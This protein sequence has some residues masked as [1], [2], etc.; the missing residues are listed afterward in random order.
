MLKCPVVL[1]CCFALA[2]LFQSSAQSSAQS[3]DP[4]WID[5]LPKKSRASILWYADHEKGD[6]S[7]WE[8]VNCKYPGGG[9]F[10]TGG[11][12]AIAQA[13]DLIAHSGRYSAQATIRGAVRA[14][15]GNRAVRLMR[16]TDRPW[17]HGGQYLPKSAYYSV[18]FF[19]PKA[20]NANKYPPWDPGDG[21]WWN[22]FQFKADDEAG[23]SQ[24]IW[25][26]NVYHDDATGT[27]DLGLYSHVNVPASIEQIKPKPIPIGRWFHLEAFYRV[28]YEKQGEITIWQDGQRILHAGNV[29]TAICLE[30]EHAVWGIGN[31]TDHIAGGKTEGS[32]SIYFD[33]AVISTQR[34]GF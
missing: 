19:L 11:K 8:P 32:C 10:N 27:L 2:I 30:N 15:N 21:G 13:T 14:A 31:Y 4:L 9:I 16:W 3:E 33:D 34:I 29:K 25:S 5:G 22:I 1:Q 24:P 18:W 17:D 20:Y 28:S 23:E 6:L 7:E 12:E 26:L